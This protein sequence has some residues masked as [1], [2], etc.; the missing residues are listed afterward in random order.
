MRLSSF[1]PLL[2][3]LP[4]LTTAQF[5]VPSAPFSLVVLS[6]AN[7]TL[8]GTSLYACHEGAA[9]EG[10]CLNNPSTAHDP[11]YTT[12]SHNTSSSVPANSSIGAP[13]SLIWVL[14]G[15]SFNEPETLSLIINPISNVAL[16]LFWPTSDSQTVAFDSNDLLNIQGYF[17][18]RVSPIDPSGGYVAYYRWYVCVTYF[19][20]YTYEALAWVLGE[21]P[22]EN[23]TC[24]AVSVKRVF[25]ETRGV[26]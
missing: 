7:S 21:Y 10:L 15:G 2:A 6:E 3:L 8:N 11:K 1:A 23:P 12:Y 18:G 4:S 22:P 14:P 17:D 26:Y 19:Q 13:G 25:L 24:Q 16:P 5:D 9:V 20:G